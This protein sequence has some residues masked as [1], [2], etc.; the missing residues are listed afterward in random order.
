M[1]PHIQ[2]TG[3][4]KTFDR[5]QSPVTVFENFNLNINHGEFV[6]L[7][8]SSGCGKSTLLRIIAGLESCNMGE[9]R[10]GNNIKN[11]PSQVGLIF[12]E[13]GLFPWMSLKNNINFI[14]ENNPQINKKHITEISERY[15]QKVGLSKFADYYPHQ[16]SGGMR[17]RISVARSFANNPDIMLLDEPF[18]FLDYQ[19]RLSLHELLLRLWQ[20]SQKTV[21][22]VTHDIEEAVLLSKRVVILADR[23]AR[24]R[25]EIAVEL[26]ESLSLLERRKTEFFHETVSEIIDLI[27][28]DF[29]FKAES[30]APL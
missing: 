26:D 15:L 16:V 12:Q 20:E 4:G 9:V 13:H 23:P 21:L 6:A 7:V 8:G 2:L 30:P 18:V 17:Q 29:E 19:S 3:L 28:T 22:F 11:Q 27:K 5:Q 24:I 25:A 1:L 14:L 10:L